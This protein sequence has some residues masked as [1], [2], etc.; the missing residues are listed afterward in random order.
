M[1][2]AAI[3]LALL[4]VLGV[5]SS[6]AETK[7]TILTEDFPPLNYLDKKTPTGP[8]V[9]IVEA[10]KKKLGIKSR[11]KVLSWKKA[12]DKAL[13]NK[14]TC[15]FS[16]TR[17][18]KR[19]KL[20]KWVGPLAEKRNVFF[21]AK[22]SKIKIT[23]LE[24]AK[25]YRV[26]VQK[27]GMSEEFLKSQGFRLFDKASTPEISMKRLYLGRVDLWYTSSTT[28]SALASKTG[29]SIANFEEVFVVKKTSLYIA[30]N[31]NTPDNV[32]KQWQDALDE[33][34]ENGTIKTIF[35]KYKID[36][37]VPMCK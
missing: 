18:E 30:F 36:A 2:K 14:N 21:A 15:V 32:I 3:I 25:S 29:I 34:T 23:S 13:K 11:V 6:F 24:D 17:T 33:L 26:G 20:F 5:G 1:K 10:I 19:E 9:E 27:G 22:N 12:H 28:P 31:I 7:I 4:L 37:L 8:S 16:T 35:E